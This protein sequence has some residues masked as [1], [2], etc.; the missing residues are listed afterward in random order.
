MPWL[1]LIIIPMIPIY[2]SIQHRYRHASRDIKRLSSN[3]LSPIYTHFTET[4]QGLTTIKAM[5][6]S[7]RFNRDFHVKLEESIKAQLT[8]AAAQQWLS[9]RLQMLGTLLVGGAG[10][11]A[12]ITSAHATNPGLVGLSVSYALSITG[13]LGGVLNALAETEQEMI[14]VERI[15]QYLQ[16][17]TE[18]NYDGTI[19]PPFA[20]PSQGVVRF[21]NVAMKYREHLTPAISNINFTT[22][23][24][25]RIA[26]V[27]RTGA[28]KSS[29][30]SA[31]LRVAPLSL[32][33]ISVDCVNIKNLALKIL[34]D[35]IVIIPQEPFLFEGLLL[36]NFNKKI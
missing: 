29:I 15:D 19:D 27:G 22:M 35:R 2:I 12:A 36:K 32:G 28:G 7:H 11:L 5:R 17:E 9:L 16:L 14:A 4:I 25:E 13:L 34:R 30:L 24:F 23:A 21:E 10:L 3:A 18:E 20:W 26:I 31:L 1:G 8:M 33:E 6:A